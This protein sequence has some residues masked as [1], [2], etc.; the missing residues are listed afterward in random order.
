MYAKS[1]IICP[2]RR[3]ALGRHAGRD[4]LTLYWTASGIELL[5]DGAELWVDFAC[6]YALY[7]PWV[8]VELNSAW[9]AR[10][11]VSPGQSRVW[12][13]SARH[14]CLYLRRTQPPRH[15]RP[16]RRRRGTDRLL[17]GKAMTGTPLPREGR[18][19]F[20]ELY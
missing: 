17:E 7:E 18:F 9:Y 20:C 12:L 3:A 6:D 10:F 16:P 13:L 14:N 1:R 2:A 8:S 5:F 11:A 4:P 15:S 19:L